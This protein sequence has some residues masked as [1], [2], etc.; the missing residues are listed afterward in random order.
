MTT[1]FKYEPTGLFRKAVLTLT[2]PRRWRSKTRPWIFDNVTGVRF[3]LA[4]DEDAL[5]SRMANHVTK[6]SRTADP[7]VLGPGFDRIASAIME[8]RR[9]YV[10]DWCRI[11]RSTPGEWDS[12]LGQP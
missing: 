7:S 3:Q 6:A 5:L 12:L 11:A 1:R 2:S 10:S 8:K 9:G 4:E